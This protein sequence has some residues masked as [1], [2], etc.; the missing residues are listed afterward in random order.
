MVD[1]FPFE[2]SFPLQGLYVPHPA[3]VEP[4]VAGFRSISSAKYCHAIIL[5]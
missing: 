2:T 4:C 1:R 3:A 5:L